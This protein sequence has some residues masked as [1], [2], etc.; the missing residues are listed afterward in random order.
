VPK[1][2]DPSGRPMHSRFYPEPG[3]VECA[4]CGREWNKGADEPDCEYE[5]YQSE[6]E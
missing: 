2:T 5:E 1:Q 4:I 6:G 3:K